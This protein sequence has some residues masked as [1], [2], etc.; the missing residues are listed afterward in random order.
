[1]SFFPTISR[2]GKESLP[3][4]TGT[5]SSSKSKQDHHNIDAAAAAAAGGEGILLRRRLSCSSFNNNT[6]AAAESDQ[7]WSFPCSSRSKSFSFSFS[8]RNWWDCTW[9]WILSRK[10]IFATDLEMNEHET[11]LL[12]S[13]DKGSWKHVFYRMRSE[14]RR[15]TNSDYCTPLPQTYTAKH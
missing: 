4:S 6:P 10:P 14:I 5:R 13:R 15:I 3:V 1:M 11:K 7:T 9:A 8:I 12:A 2:S